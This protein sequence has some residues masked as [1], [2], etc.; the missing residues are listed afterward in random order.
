MAKTLK[1][2]V[3]EQHG[4]QPLA[5]TVDAALCPEDLARH[6]ELRV[7]AVYGPGPAV[8]AG[9]HYLVVGE[10]RLDTPAVE[11]IVLAN[12]GRM[13]G[14]HE[15]LS[16]GSAEFAVYGQALEVAPGTESRLYLRAHPREGEDCP[17]LTVTLLPG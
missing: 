15:F 11:W 13:T 1:E 12:S 5:F 2:S 16:P 4:L 9:G 6:L 14:Y 10:A 8:T 7:T 3:L 17:V